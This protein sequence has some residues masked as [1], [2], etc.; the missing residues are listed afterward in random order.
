MAKI[1]LTDSSVDR[2]STS[3]V[4]EDFWHS[5]W[6]YRGSFGLRVSQTG[7]KTWVWLES[8]KE[9]GKT[10]K[11]RHKLGLYPDMVLAEALQEA[12]DRAKVQAAHGWIVEDLAR[13]L[14]RRYE[15]EEA[16]PQT[17]KSRSNMMEFHI[18]PE[19]GHIAVRETT[20]PLL[21][22]L[23]DD[24][25]NEGKFGKAADL[26]ATLRQ[27]FKPVMRKGLHSYNPA[28]GLQLTKRDRRSRRGV[29]ASVDIQV[30][31]WIWNA[32]EKLRPIALDRGNRT[33]AAQY[34]GIQFQIAS[35]Q[36]S[37]VI[38]E[39]DRECLEQDW[40]VHPGRYTVEHRAP[41]ARKVEERV[42]LTKGKKTESLLPM[43]VPIT[44]SM[45]SRLQLLQELA[46]GRRFLLA[47][48]FWP[49][50]HWE[51]QVIANL[52][53][54]SGETGK[55]WW[56]HR[57]RK[58]AATLLREAGV[59]RDNYRL[60]LHHKIEDDVTARFYEEENPRRPERITAML[61]WD[62]MLRSAIARSKELE[63]VNGG[64][65]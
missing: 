24:A 7:R 32:A 15:L 65:A 40:W 28:L 43:G 8:W 58:V 13:E 1:N 36:R 23:I 34:L 17:I 51:N 4:Q 26:S 22:K 30:L 16:S 14:I 12:T 64:A 10:K 45:R 37:R 2:L 60:A 62:E 57:V 21:Q 55:T 59:P 31:V 33:H 44:D 53:R 52:R 47:H 18:L 27:M 11:R 54:E 25:E 61:R 56:P 6:P 19:I 50:E 42:F 5:K 35:L 20:T 48:D 49:P 39:L 41:G 29:E 9:D 38:C 46:D 63:V 3:K